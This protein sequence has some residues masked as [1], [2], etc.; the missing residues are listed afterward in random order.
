MGAISL[1]AKSR[2]AVRS[3]LCSSEAPRSTGGKDRA[4]IIEQ[5]GR[6]ADSLFRWVRDQTNLLPYRGAL[7]GPVGVLMDRGGNSL[8][9]SLLLAQLLLSAGYQ[10][11]LANAALP[12][13][14]VLQLLSSVKGRAN[15]GTTDESSASDE[16]KAARLRV[17]QH[18]EKLLAEV[19]GTASGPA[20]ADAA[21][22]AAL[23]DH[24]WVQRQSGGRWVDLDPT[25]PEA[26]PGQSTLQPKR[27]VG[28]PLAGGKL[29]LDA[30]DCHEVEL[31]I[32]IEAWRVDQ[33]KTATV[34]HHVLRPA[35]TLDRSVRFGQSRESSSTQSSQRCLGGNAARCTRLGP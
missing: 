23:A 21:Q 35:Q 30:A 25:L 13:D 19:G 27:T 12:K 14:Q 4:A 31:R 24:W 8:D 3:I 9:R 10:V 32:V 15:Q 18:A 2:T 34:L 17:A 7:R 6:D 1:E 11:R 26:R 16:A 33:L 22:A 28:V 20:V 29:A 5:V